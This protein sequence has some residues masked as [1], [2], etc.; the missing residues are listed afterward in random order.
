MVKNNIKAGLSM[1]G[2]TTM[3][4]YVLK[5]YLI[6]MRCRFYSPA[7][8]TLSVLA[9][10]PAYVVAEVPLAKYSEKVDIWSAD[11]ILH[12]LLVQVD[13]VSI[14][15]G[16]WKSEILSLETLILASHD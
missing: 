5:A 12:A 2:F 4:N 3:L 6:H 9:G 16:R 8:Q 1:L 15:S 11:I 14:R 7:D 10:S 13:V